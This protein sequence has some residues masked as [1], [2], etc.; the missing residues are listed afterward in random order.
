MC[1]TRSPLDQLFRK[2]I[3]DAS[4]L[5]G[6]KGLPSKPLIMSKLNNLGPE[7]ILETLREGI[8]SRPQVLAFPVLIHL[9]EGKK[10]L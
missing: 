1:W 7:G 2:P 6:K 5:V 8:G 3:F 9:C 4:A 10:V